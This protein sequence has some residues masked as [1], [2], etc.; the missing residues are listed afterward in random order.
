[1]KQQKVCVHYNIRKQARKLTRAL[2]VQGYLSSGNVSNRGKK[3]PTRTL[4]GGAGTHC[5]AENTN[6][7]N[8]KKQLS[9]FLKKYLR[10]S[11]SSATE[12]ET[13]K[14]KIKLFIAQMFS[15]FSVADETRQKLTSI[16]AHTA[17]I[18]SYATC[19]IVFLSKESN[20]RWTRCNYCS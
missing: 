8:Q 17:S 9:L 6:R 4:F 10:Q 13:K 16:S 15:K 12:S 7:H 19:S 20:G 5:V 2:K 18:Y 14:S 11:L 1:M 3:E